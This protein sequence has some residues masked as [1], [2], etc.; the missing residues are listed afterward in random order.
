MAVEKS[1]NNTSLGLSALYEIPLGLGSLLMFKALRTSVITL[2][3]LAY[4]SK[5][6][7]F[8]RWNILSGET[9]EKPQQLPRYMMTAP[10]WNPHA[11]VS[12]A[13]PVRVN[14]EVVLELNDDIDQV[15]Y[16]YFGVWHFPSFESKGYVSSWNKPDDK[17]ITLSLPPGDYYIA[18]RYYH[19]PKDVS[20]P[21]VLVDGNEIIATTDYSGNI[22]SFYNNL[23]VRDNLFYRLTQF[24]VYVMLKYQKLFSKRLVNKHFLPVGNEDTDYI[25]GIVEKDDILCFSMD[26][27][28]LKRHNVFCTVYNLSSLPVDIFEITSADFVSRK[29]P[30]RGFYLV[31]VMCFQGL[32][33]RYDDEIEVTIKKEYSGNV[34]PLLASPQ[35]QS[36]NS[37][38]PKSISDKSTPPK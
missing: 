18:C 20:Y 4:T 3:R 24:H 32:Q 10:R 23:A 26:E 8:K 9:L 6:D 13:G 22:N 35:S 7:A 17:R 28:W 12:A 33:D 36:L 14:K 5:P 19:P 1:S 31:R 34:T 25:Y 15:P 16:W 29:V 30:G 11:A 21:S 27:A 37:E 2:G 38:S